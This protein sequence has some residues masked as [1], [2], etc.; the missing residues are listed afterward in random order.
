MA[1]RTFFSFHYE[2]DIWRVNQVRNSWLT[3]PSIE[4]A[5]FIDAADFEQLKRS[6]SQAIEDW[7]DEQLRGT[8]VTC[9]LIGAE[10]ANRHW[11]QVEI[12]K[13]IAKGNGFVGIYLNNI[14]APGQG[15]ELRGHNP[16]DDFTIPAT[17]GKD[18]PLSD[19]YSTYDWVYNDGYNNLGA[20]VEA[21]AKKAGR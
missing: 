8:S 4:A 18:Y 5:G 7:I 1:R 6:G 19:F 14:K 15:A 11:V 20:W 3:H 10:T 12:E 2:R 21:A 13:S 16:L 17:D 9:V